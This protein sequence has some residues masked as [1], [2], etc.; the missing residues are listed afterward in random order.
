[1]RVQEGDSTAWRELVRLYS[2]LV[3]SVA[4]KVGLAQ[5]D[6]EDCAQQTWLTLY[7]KRKSIRD[8]QSLPA[9]LITTTH[10]NAV[11]TFKRLRSRSSQADFDL[12]EDPGSLPDELLARMERRAILE[13]ALAQLDSRCQRLL[14]E[15]YFG[16]SESSY[17]QLAGKLKVKPNSIGSIRSRC[18]EKLRKTLKEM[19]YDPD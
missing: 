2:D 6:A 11:A 10:R 4:L 5:P 15:L 16:K 9:W 3:Y 17:T 7:R 1:M 12:L 8:P 13:T 19:G 14:H 18:L